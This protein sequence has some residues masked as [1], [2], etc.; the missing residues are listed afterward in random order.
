VT[1]EGCHTLV[2]VWCGVCGVTHLGVKGVTP[3]IGECT[4][5]GSR[6]CAGRREPVAV[7]GGCPVGRQCL[8]AW[9]AAA[10][11]MG[12]DCYNIH[13]RSHFWMCGSMCMSAWWW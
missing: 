5:Y 11:G 13:A 2:G 3:M 7:L 6:P 12:G 10:G 1:F 9:D 8:E 4:S